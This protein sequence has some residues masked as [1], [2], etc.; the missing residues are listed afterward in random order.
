MENKL[1]TRGSNNET[2]NRITNNRKGSQAIPNIGY[3]DA[4]TYYADSS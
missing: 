3:R 1:L 2:K 4:D